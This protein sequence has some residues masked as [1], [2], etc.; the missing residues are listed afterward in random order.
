MFQFRLPDIGEGI[1]EGEIVKWHVNKGDRINRDQDMVEVMT[2]KV[3]VKIPSPVEGTVSSISVPEGKVAKVGDLL[4]EIDDGSSGVTGNVEARVEPQTQPQARTVE[5]VAERTGEKKVLASPAIRKAARDLGVNLEDVVPTGPNGRILME[6]IET[7]K[8]GK[9]KKPESAP[10]GAQTSGQKEA[11]Q[12]QVKDGVLFEPKGLRRIIFEKMTKSK[13]LLPHFTIVESVD[14]TRLKETRDQLAKKD[15]AITYTPLFI[16]AITNVLGEFPRFNAHYVEDR[17][18][19]IIRKTINIGMAVD[20]PDGLTVAVIKDTNGKTVQE[21]SKEVRDL[22]ERAKKGQLKINE[23]QDSTFTI[24]NVGTIGGISSSP[25]I[26]YPE[27]AIAGFHRMINS[28]EGK[29]EKY[30]MNVSLSCDHRLIDGADAARFINRL[31]ELL[32]NPALIIV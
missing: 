13:A 24:S 5:P 1:A 30:E 18:A 8:A 20:T 16:K 11:S 32:E 2:D 22:A 6:D 3:T 27:V 17:K 23:V 12:T 26:N 7:A 29:V 4:I 14:M 15:N 25:I 21:I 19:Y 9:K 28:T 31:K 10:A